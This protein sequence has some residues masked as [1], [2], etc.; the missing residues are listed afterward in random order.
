MDRQRLAVKSSIIGLGS[1]FIATVL[2]FVCRKFFL[3]YLGTELL[4]VN[5]TLTQILETLSLSELGIQTAIIFQ[6][7]KPL[8]EGKYEQVSKVMTIIRR[9]Y[10]VVGTFILFLGIVLSPILKKLITRVDVDFS[11]VYIVY[12][13]MLFGTATS[14]FFS[15]SRALLQADQKM[16][17][18]NI[19]DSIIQIMTSLARIISLIVLHSFIAYAIIGISYSIVSNFASYL[20]YRKKYYW[21]DIR[22]KSDKGL[23]RTLINNTKNVFVGKMAGYVYSSTDN[24]VISALVGTSWVALVGNYS[25]ITN[26]IKVVIFGLVAP[27]QPMIGNYVVEKSKDETEFVLYNYGFIR[28]MLAVFLLIPT[29]C[30]SDMFIE[31]FYGY[32]FVM[33]KNISILLCV[34]ILIILLQGDV[35]DLIDALGFFKQ[36]RNLYIAYAIINLSLSCIGAKLWGVGAVLVA[37]VISQSIGWIWR[38]IIAYQYYFKSKE[39][40]IHYWNVHIKYILYFICNMIIVMFILRN[41]HIK[42]S[43]I[44]FALFGVLI[45]VVSVIMFCFYFRKTAEFNYFLSLIKKIR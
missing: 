41:V 15:Y 23:V 39:K 20:Y 4:G 22:T 8:V 30:L 7:Y 1:K 3:K 43:Y 24:L 25:T 19:I 27:I 9:I 37:T 36:E 35:G 45:E 6:L 38:C 11:E 26:A 16:Y 21:V 17:V 14:Y 44:S 42:T 29:I 28:F 34:D 32:E 31:I 40:F 12:Y 13:I 18:N 33:N 5:G 10:V 2:L